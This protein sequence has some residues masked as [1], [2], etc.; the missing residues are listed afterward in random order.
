VRFKLDHINREYNVQNKEV[1]K[2]KIVRPR[3]AQATA[4]PR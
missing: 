4:R 1:A 3:P 2:K